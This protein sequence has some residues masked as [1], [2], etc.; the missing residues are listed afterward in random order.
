MGDQN[1]NQGSTLGTEPA[2]DLIR[3]KD[4]VY[5]VSMRTTSPKTCWGRDIRALLQAAGES[6][7]AHVWDLSVGP[8]PMGRLTDDQYVHFKPSVAITL[9]YKAENSLQ[10][11]LQ[12]SSESEPEG[13]EV[14][15]GPVEDDS[16]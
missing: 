2:A 5:D 16:V 9:Q 13:Q 12:S 4:N 14:D 3:R 6:R 8:R 10:A 1:T 7:F 15:A 11:F